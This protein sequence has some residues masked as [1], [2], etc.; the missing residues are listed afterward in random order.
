M[1]LP[2]ATV[3]Q[4]SV[5]LEW[6]ST[7]GK[8]RG[9]YTHQAGDKGPT[10]T[11]N[12]RSVA[13]SPDGKLMATGGTSQTGGEVELWNTS[14][15]KLHFSLPRTVLPIG[16]LRLLGKG[17]AA[18]VRAVAFSPDGKTLATCSDGSRVLLSLMVRDLLGSRVDDPGVVKLWNVDTGQES[19]CSAKGNHNLCAFL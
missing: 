15:G 3:S 9:G 10:Y 8:Q 16:A 17:H 18:R 2:V 12:I 19:P 7:H 13:F 14:T 5:K 11:G 1:V 4:R 6:T